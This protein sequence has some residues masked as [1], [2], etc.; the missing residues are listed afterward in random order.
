MYFH[1]EIGLTDFLTKILLELHNQDEKIPTDIFSLLNCILIDFDYKSQTDLRIILEIYKLG[2]DL[3]DRFSYLKKLNDYRIKLDQSLPQPTR[4][5]F[6][7]KEYSQKVFDFI[8]NFVINSGS[9]KEKK[10]W[11][12]EKI[13]IIASND[14][15]HRIIN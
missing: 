11:E 2:Q 14:E 13:N 7:D 9:T 12:E 6:I 5:Y 4:A 3:T 1:K 15:N 10:F 8:D